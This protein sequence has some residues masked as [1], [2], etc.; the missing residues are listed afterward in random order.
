[1]TQLSNSFTYDQLE[2]IVQET[3]ENAAAASKMDGKGREH[4]EKAKSLLKT[5][6]SRVHEVLETFGLSREV[7]NA[8]AYKDNA[9][10]ETFRVQWCT[11]LT[12]ARRESTKV[13]KTGDVLFN[14]A[15]KKQWSRMI[16]AYRENNADGTQSAADIEAKAAKSQ[17]NKTNEMKAMI[18]DALVDSYERLKNYEDEQG[19]LTPNT[20][21]HD[22]ASSHVDASM[23]AVRALLDRAANQAALGVTK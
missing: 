5:V 20:P 2:A 3:T 15:V 14:D 12:K 7:E 13:S 10:Y 6:Y 18:F 22:E 4:L 8:K 21:E 9:D 1:M 16:T 11:A 19:A 23:A 17:R